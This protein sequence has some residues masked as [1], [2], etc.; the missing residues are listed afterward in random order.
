MHLE[1]RLSLDLG[2]NAK[3]V[4]D[5]VR[6]PEMKN[7]RAQTNIKLEKNLILIHIKAGDKT[8]LKASLNSCL[9]SIILAKNLLEVN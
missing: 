8:A 9:K 4:F 3:I 7:N 1:C 6:R 5:S 2:E